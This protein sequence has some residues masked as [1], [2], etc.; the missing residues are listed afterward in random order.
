VSFSLINNRFGVETF[1]TWGIILKIGGQILSKIIVL[2]SRYTIF[3]VTFLM[4][5]IVRES[6]SRLTY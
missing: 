4:N 5:L 2:V 6:V 1:K 3:G